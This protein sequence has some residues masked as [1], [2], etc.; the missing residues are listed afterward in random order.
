V[1]AV[2]A[3]VSKEHWAALHHARFAL[4]WVY[5]GG[6][7]GDRCNGHEQCPDS[8]V[9]PQ[10]LLVGLWAGTTERR[11]GIEIPLTPSERGHQP[12]VTG[13]SAG[14]WE[15]SDIQCK[16]TLSV[17]GSRVASNASG[18]KSISLRQQQ[19]SQPLCHTTAVPLLSCTYSV[20][21]LLDLGSV[22]LP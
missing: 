4:R 12:R 9:T 2:Q 20:A 13:R 7:G 17:S 14:A 1:P 5:P 11:K 15:G 8:G 16:C 10:G 21:V 22:A 18:Q 19:P 6:L 3:P